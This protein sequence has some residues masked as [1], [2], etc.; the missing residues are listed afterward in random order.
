[1][2]NTV[3]EIKRIA[4]EKIPDEVIVEAHLQ[5]QHLAH[6]ALEAA[7]INY[8]DTSSAQRFLRGENFYDQRPFTPS[9]FS[10]GKHE[11]V[12]IKDY[13]NAQYY[14]TVEVG[15]PGQSFKVIFDTGSSNLWVPKVGCSH[16]GIPIIAPKQKYDE[17]KSSTYEAD[18]APF[19]ITYGELIEQFVDLNKGYPH[20]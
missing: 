3:A 18:G 13:Q 15:S 12:I 10:L 9:D 8:H 7:G 14:G 5:R 4:L 11:N 6:K 2:G 16:C 19:D 20:F 1:M 17:S